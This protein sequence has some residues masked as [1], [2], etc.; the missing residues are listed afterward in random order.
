MMKIV[1]YNK[2]NK[3][4]ENDSINEND[5]LIRIDSDN[6]EDVNLVKNDFKEEIIYDINLNKNIKSI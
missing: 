6:E 4:S 5:E 3:R 1:I 2:F